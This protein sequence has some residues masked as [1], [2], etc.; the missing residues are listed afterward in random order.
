M[1]KGQSS[2]EASIIL[3][4]LM[5]F[6]TFFIAGIG[7][8]LIGTQNENLADAISDNADRLESELRTAA[9]YEDGFVRNISLPDKIRSLDY[10]VEFS[11]KSVTRGNFTQIWLSNPKGGIHVRQLPGN[12]EGTALI[13]VGQNVT[14]KKQDGILRINPAIPPP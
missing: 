7:N 3:G 10:V 8:I 14:L 4:V 12:I 9:Y 1:K 13:P 2:L 6:F 11:N 5:V